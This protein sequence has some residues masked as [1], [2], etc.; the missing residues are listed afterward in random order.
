MIAVSSSR[1]IRQVYKTMIREPREVPCEVFPDSVFE[2]LHKTVGKR[3]TERCDCV[4]S[5]HGSHD[6]CEEKWY[7]FNKV[8]DFSSKIG[9]TYNSN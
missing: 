8:S 9:F 7:L 1:M 6:G 3:K 4:D 5:D 2:A